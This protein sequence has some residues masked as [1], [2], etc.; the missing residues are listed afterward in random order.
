MTLLDRIEDKIKENEYFVKVCSSEESHDDF[1]FQAPREHVLYLGLKEEFYNRLMEKSPFFSVNP[2]LI[3]GWSSTL[4]PTLQ[5]FEP[6][7]MQQ[8]DYSKSFYGFEM[9][10]GYH[11]FRESLFEDV[12]M[13]RLGFA[14][15]ELRKVPGISLDSDYFEADPIEIFRDIHVI[16]LPSVG[17]AKYAKLQNVKPGNLEKLR[18]LKYEITGQ[19]KKRGTRL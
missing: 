17:Y 7:S 13:S 11:S 19:T 15:P 3:R 2:S 4:F 10:F 14:N 16:E 12:K 6:I 1:R 5:G 8:F 18:A 9:Q